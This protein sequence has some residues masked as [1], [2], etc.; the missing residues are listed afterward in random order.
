MLVAREGPRPTVRIVSRFLGAGSDAF[1]E[2]AAS[3]AKRLRIFGRGVLD[4]HAAGLQRLPATLDR[5][6]PPAQFA[7]MK[8]RTCASSTSR[9]RPAVFKRTRA[10]REP[11]VQQLAVAPLRRRRSPRIP[12]LPRCSARRAA[13]IQRQPNE[14]SSAIRPTLCPLAEASPSE[15]SRRLATSCA[16]NYV[17]QRFDAQ[18]R[19]F[20][21]MVSPLPRFIGDEA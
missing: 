8:R 15:N 2:P 16:T 10:C 12:G 17:P 9:H 1:F 13:P 20:I 7:R 11:R 14:A 6:P 21:V 4:R 5:D 19:G 3:R 18:M